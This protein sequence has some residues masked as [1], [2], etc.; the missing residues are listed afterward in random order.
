MRRLVIRAYPF[1]LEILHEERLLARH[2]RCY[3]REQDVLD[4]LHYLPLLLERP[5]AFEHAKPI[6]RW[7]ESWPP[8]YARLLSRLRTQW[9]DGQGVLL[10]R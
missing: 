4:P 1:H 10:T 5:G 3:D 7:R 6:R 9:P 2:P 8:S